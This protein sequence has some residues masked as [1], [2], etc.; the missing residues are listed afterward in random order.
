M[1]DIIKASFIEQA[2][3]Q[4]SEYNLSW[5]EILQQTDWLLSEKG[6]DDLL[7]A[8]QVRD[9][10]QVNSAMTQFLTG[11]AD[12]KREIVEGGESK[13]DIEAADWFRELIG[14]GATKKGTSGYHNS[15]RFNN[16]IKKMGWSYFYGYGVAEL[17][18]IKDRDGKV[19]LDFKKG[20]IRVRHRRR[21]RIDVDLNIRVRTDTSTWDGEVMHPSRVWSM[22]GIG[23]D[24]DD[25]PYGLGR[26][27]WLYWL[28]FFKRGGV[29]DQAL[30]LTVA[31][32]PKVGV[33]YP[34]GGGEAAKNDADK[35]GLRLSKGSKW[36][37]HTDEL[38][39]K[40]LESTRT[41]FAD[42]SAFVEWCNRAIVETILLQNVTS[43]EA[44]FKGD[45]QEN[46]KDILI[47]SCAKEIFES[48]TD[49]VIAKLCYY[50]FG[51]D[52]NPPALRMLEPPED[53]NLIIERDIKAKDLGL[54]RSEESRKELYPDYEEVQADAKVTLLDGA[55]QTALQQLVKDCAGGLVPPDTAEKLVLT[56][57]VSEEQAKSYIDPIRAAIAE[58][59]AEAEKQA[60]E[61]DVFGDGE[62]TEED[63]ES[64]GNPI[65]DELGVD[66]NQL[67]E[68]EEEEPE[69]VQEF[70]KGDG[71]P[72]GRGY[73]TKSKKCR[74]G[75]QGQ[76]ADYAGF[77]NSKLSKIDRLKSNIKT[78]A[79]EILQ[80][81]KDN[82]GKI[83]TEA[84][85]AATGIIA[86]KLGAN[87]VVASAAGTT[88]RAAIAVGK[89]AYDN[90]QKAKAEMVN[91]NGKNLLQAAKQAA[92]GTV[93]DL[94]S[95]VFREGVEKGFMGDAGYAA[96]AN[97]AGALFGASPL[98][99]T[100]LRVL[101][102]GDMIALADPL[103]AS[104]T[105]LKAKD[106]IAKA[107]KDSPKG[108][109]KSAV[110]NSFLNFRDRIAFKNPNM[111]ME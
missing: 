106:S 33:S 43:K 67:E 9:D 64:T 94:K 22:L 102:V 41:G 39:V 73:I 21:F 6:N 17:M 4:T 107:I 103:K 79:G 11:I 62:G 92:Q 97:L 32:D 72:C 37:S 81:V 86:S 34:S 5:G 1:A 18:L 28:V 2:S 89:V 87:P 14:I 71:Y 56:Y 47:A 25:E 13:K 44:A 23:S 98:A 80:T 50:R 90:I 55:Q 42:F 38:I 61:Q 24:H 110:K 53:I 46:T 3:L 82:K 99:K 16:L 105:L 85:V 20:G 31:A 58:S 76:A 84:A 104:A 7:L 35:L 74:K 8:E 51:A 93:S 77:L 26:W 59:K 63:T 91:G 45:V 95:K 40:Y 15:L 66:P 52:V 48:F 60:A 49:Q 78:K 88:T 83:A 54:K 57:G 10:E 19:T 30:G 100:V 69:E 36:F 12:V 70:A 109:L 29:R 65:L 111:A 96:T 75:L 101:P 68:P 108:T 27:H